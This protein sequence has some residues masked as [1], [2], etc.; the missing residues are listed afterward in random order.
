MSES[1]QNSITEQPVTP[2]QNKSEAKTPNLS[3]SLSPT[4]S[5]KSNSSETGIK[6]PIPNKKPSSF[7]IMDLLNNNN[8]ESI[9]DQPKK[10]QKLSDA[11]S[12]HS[13]QSSS[14]ASSRSTTPNAVNIKKPYPQ[15]QTKQAF[16]HFNPMQILGGASIEQFLMHQHFIQNNSPI[17]GFNH[18]PSQHHQ[19]P[20]E[21][22]DMQQKFMFMQKILAENASKFNEQ[23]A[24]AGEF[25]KV[26]N[27]QRKLEDLTTSSDCTDSSVSFKPKQLDSD[28]EEINDSDDNDLN[29]HQISNEDDEDCDS[30][31][32]DENSRSA[33]ARRARTAFTY[34]QLV[35]LENKFKQTRYLSVCE[36]LNLA[37]SL[38]LTETQ[39]KIWFQNR[40]TKWKKQNPGCDVNSPTHAA[41]QAAHA[42]V[43]NAANFLPSH[44]QNH[45]SQPHHQSSM[46]NSSQSPYAGL[47]HAAASG[48]YSP[49]A[50][51]SS[52]LLIPQLSPSSM[53]SATSSPNNQNGSHNTSSSSPSSSSGGSI[54]S[55]HHQQHQ[56]SH[57]Q[58]ALA[59]M[60]NP[61]YAA[62]AAAGHLPSFFAAAAAAQSKFARV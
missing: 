59:M 38:S 46:G 12:S 36:R 52:E 18:P 57:H 2:P 50:K 49:S 44:L 5:I 24:S 42:A 11:N 45:H 56:N 26:H 39:V 40:R 32:D 13:S 1:E 53:S 20:N 30:D 62:A 22:Y 61:F 41:A 21:T 25:N 3:M 17:F 16:Q 4:A 8:N 60:S 34:E 47:L 58:A 55:Q 54:S 15:Q 23:Q 28:N 48:F 10:K 51:S 33:K 6:K 43:A 9:E 35:A 7:N 29:N 31:S 37:L 14:S 27:K 19:T